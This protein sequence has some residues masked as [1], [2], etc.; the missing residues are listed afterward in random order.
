MNGIVYSLK[1]MRK[2]LDEI[3]SEFE[4]NEAILERLRKENSELRDE[5]YKDK[6]LALLKAK[7]ADAEREL[8]RGFSIS[9]EEETNIKKWKEFHEVVHEGGHGAVGGKYTYSFIPTSIGTI[10]EIRCS[11][12]ESFCFSDI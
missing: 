11:C 12:G 7:L 10:G 3:A 2:R 5:K 6:E 4:R 1:P 8:H 9:E